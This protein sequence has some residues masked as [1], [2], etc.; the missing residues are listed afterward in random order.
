MFSISI[1]E[2]GNFELNKL[3]PLDC[4]NQAGFQLELV[5]GLAPPP[6]PWTCFKATIGFL[7]V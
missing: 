4:D 1:Q 7:G 5:N 2:F 6:R 3:N